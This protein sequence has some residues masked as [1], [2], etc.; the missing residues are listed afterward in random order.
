MAPPPVSPPCWIY[1]ACMMNDLKSTPAML[2]GT[3]LERIS[4]ALAAP[5]LYQI[6]QAI[7]ATD[8]R[9]ACS[10]QLEIHPISAAT[11]SHH[12]KEPERAELIHFHR[13]GKFKS[14][15]L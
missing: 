10:M 3:Q 13:D 1:G 5:R 8:G 7:G 15:T 9:C 4:Q 6:L 2:T 14:M 11:L 12:L